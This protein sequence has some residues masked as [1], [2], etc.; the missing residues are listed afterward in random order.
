M[1]LSYDIGDCVMSAY[2]VR[3]ITRTNLIIG[4]SKLY[5]LDD[6][7]CDARQCKK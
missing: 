3:K 6:H 4:V 1:N 5:V 2:T 7:L